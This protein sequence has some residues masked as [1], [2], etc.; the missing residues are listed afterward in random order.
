[1][2]LTNAQTT[3]LFQNSAQMGIP[4]ETVVQL[5]N[6]GITT[7]E[8]LMDFYKDTIQQVTDSLRRPVGRIPDPTPNAAPGATIP[9]PPFVFGANSQ[10]RL[11]AACDIV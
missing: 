7:I 2:F 6:E 11:L 9:T 8:Y 10:K 4:D 1:M 3:A 5:V